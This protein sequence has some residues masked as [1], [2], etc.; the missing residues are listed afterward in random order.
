[1]TDNDQPLPQLPP[2]VLSPVD[3]LP[4][5]QHRRAG[6]E[7][8]FIHIRE[9]LSRLHWC[10]GSKSGPIRCTSKPGRRV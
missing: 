2:E 9:R 7:P 5:P 1:M 6:L 4:P 3:R 10:C 8:R